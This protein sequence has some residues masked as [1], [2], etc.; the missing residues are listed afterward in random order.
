MTPPVNINKD[1]LKT[2]ATSIAMVLGMSALLFILLKPHHQETI[3]V[4]KEG[5]GIS[6]MHS[7]GRWVLIKDDRK[8]DQVDNITPL[9]PGV[10]L[11]VYE[12]EKTIDIHIIKK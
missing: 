3:S 1:F 5:A 4:N 7:H 10:T 8:T 11:K 2:F 9:E 12:T 6:L